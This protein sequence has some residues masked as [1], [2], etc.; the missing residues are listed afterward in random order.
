MNHMRTSREKLHFLKMRATGN[1]Y[2]YFDCFDQQIPSPESLCVR[3]SSRR[4]G[5]GGDG[6]VLI[7]PS[8]VA[9]AKMRM[10][11]ADGSEGE[12][13]GNA[14]R[15]VGK[16]LYE[17]GR[18]RKDQ[19]VL[20]TGGGLRALQL[21]LREETVYSVCVKMGQPD[22][23]PKAVPM[24][25]KD[26]AIRS[27]VMLAGEEREI[28]CLSMGNPHCVLFVPDVDQIDIETLGPK[29][30]CDPLF[31]QRANISFAQAIDRNTFKMRVWER[32]IGE[33]WACG[34]GACAV[35]AAA[36]RCGLCD[37]DTDISLRL[38]GGELVVRY[39]EEGLW[40]TGDAQKDFEGDIE[41]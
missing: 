18:V 2:I 11:N 39:D 12:V 23:R 1:D 16:Y 17:S 7:L 19:M 4:M 34:T 20:E 21:Y 13:A 40:L 38:I 36:V 26:E 32:G 28:T 10:F 24:A 29:M 14:I 3:V 8:L 15:C 37:R 31:P 27:K 41:I 6:I 5:I 9:D 25:L 35:A 30:E 33:T 22:F